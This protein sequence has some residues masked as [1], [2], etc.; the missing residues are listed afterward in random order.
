MIRV[1][2]SGLLVTQNCKEAINS[3]KTL[4]RVSLPEGLEKVVGQCLNYCAI[5][6]IVIPKSLKTI[7]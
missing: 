4:E 3:E 6:T 7:E 5:K 2:L 1:A